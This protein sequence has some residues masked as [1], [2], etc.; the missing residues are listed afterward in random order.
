MVLHEERNELGM[1]CVSCSWRSWPSPVMNMFFRVIQ[2][3]HESEPASS[4]VPL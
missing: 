2:L 4:V 3:K 1:N